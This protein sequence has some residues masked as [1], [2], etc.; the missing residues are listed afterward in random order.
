MRAGAAGFLLSDHAAGALADAVRA[1][2]LGGAAISP[3]VAKLLLEMLEDID[4][5]RMGQARAALRQLSQREREVLECLSRGM[6]NTQIGRSLFM[7]EG[8]VKAYVSRLLVKLGCANRVQA[9]IL[10]RDA[11]LSVPPRAVAERSFQRAA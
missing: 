3:R 5:E 7:S 2:V 6:G 10:W 1:V 11:R 9:A 8:S 4:L